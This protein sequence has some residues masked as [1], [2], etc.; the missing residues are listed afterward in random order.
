MFF[1]ELYADMEFYRTA[2]EIKI[3]GGGGGGGFQRKGRGK[4]KE[5]R[6]GGKK[7]RGIIR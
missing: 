1:A 6:K 5:K 7:G 2:R 3:G 4:E